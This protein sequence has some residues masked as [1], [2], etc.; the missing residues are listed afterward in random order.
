MLAILTIEDRTNDVAVIV[1]MD[2]DLMEDAKQIV[3]ERNAKYKNQ[4]S[5][6]Q[7]NVSYEGTLLK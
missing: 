4:Y 6:I 2:D 5:F 1:V 7:Q 3:K